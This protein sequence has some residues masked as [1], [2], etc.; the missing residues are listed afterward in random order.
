MQGGFALST[1]VPNPAASTSQL[2][3]SVDAAQHVTA[4]VYDVTG[5]TV[6]EAFAGEASPGSAVRISLDMAALPPGVYV[7]RVTGET[8]V[9]SRRLVVAR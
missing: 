3:L 9:A 5:R 1:P 2:S 4:V 8:F 6:A 7:V